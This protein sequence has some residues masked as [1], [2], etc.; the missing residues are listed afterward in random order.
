[1]MPRW[2]N[3]HHFLVLVRRGTHAY[4]LHAAISLFFIHAKSTMLFSMHGRLNGYHEISPVTSRPLDS[5][6]VRSSPMGGGFQVATN[7]YPQGDIASTSNTR[8]Y[9]PGLTPESSHT[10]V[11]QWLEQTPLPAPKTF[12]WDILSSIPLM[13]DKKPTASIRQEVLIQSISLV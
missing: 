4:I 8:P 2:E 9:S 3:E 10:R 12:S 5:S 7:S 13:V 11:A 6:F 1:M